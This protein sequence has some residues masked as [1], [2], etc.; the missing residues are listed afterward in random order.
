FK[1]TVEQVFN[2]LIE[3]TD[4]AGATDEHRAINYLAVR[5][6]LVYAT[7][8]EAFRRNA[9][10]TAVEIKQSSL[11]GVCKIMDVIFSYTQRRRDVVEKFFV[12]V[13]VTGEWPYLV[14]KLSPYFDK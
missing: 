14:R 12:S 2:T 10:L 5:D 6:P 8:A 9:S 3:M 4:N 11:S 13:D 7:T 1:S